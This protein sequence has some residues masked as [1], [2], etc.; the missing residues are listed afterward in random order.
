MAD[1][2]VDQT[3]QPAPQAAPA[4]EPNFP[5]EGIVMMIYR[6]TGTE[7][8]SFRIEAPAPQE[9]SLDST[10]RQP[11]FFECTISTPPNG[12][13]AGKIVFALE[14]DLDTSA[15]LAWVSRLELAPFAADAV[16]LGSLHSQVRGSLLQFAR[17]NGA[18]ATGYLKPDAGSVKFIWSDVMLW[19][20][21]DRAITNVPILVHYHATD[22]DWGRSGSGPAD[23][24]LNILHQFIPP[25]AD[26]AAP[27][28]IN[29]VMMSRLAFGLHIPFADRF[30]LR[31]PQGG[32]R[33]AAGAIADWIEEQLK[34]DGTPRPSAPR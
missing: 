7:Q 14:T 12:E 1:R 31:L 5:P 16:D 23:L 32:G 10:M 30:L 28:T 20:E 2:A 11:V 6:T 34:A 4:S 15:K 13:P 18:E 3:K 29:G 21:S 22:F 17:L 19:R 33:I 24:A 9:L 25:G 27:L 8:Q 26:G